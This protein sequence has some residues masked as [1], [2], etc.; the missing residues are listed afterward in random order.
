MAI[1][2]LAPCYT[3]GGD[4]LNCDEAADCASGKKCYVTT[5]A[6]LG[7]ACSTSATG[8]AL[9]KQDSDCAPGVKCVTQTCNSGFNPQVLSTCGGSTW[10]TNH[11]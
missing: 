7:T 10:C 8:P 5:N 3:I 1:G 11:P 9:C 4:P 2:T 6:P